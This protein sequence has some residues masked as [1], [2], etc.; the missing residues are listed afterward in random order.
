MQSVGYHDEHGRP[1]KKFVATYDEAVAFIDKN[2]VTVSRKRPEFVAS[3]RYQEGES[4]EVATDSV[5]VVWNVYKLTD[6]TRGAVGFYAMPNVFGASALVGPAASL[7]ELRRDVFSYVEKSVLG[8]GGGS[9]FGLGGEAAGST[10]MPS[11]VY[12]APHIRSSLHVRIGP[13]SSRRR[14]DALRPGHEGGGG[15]RGRGGP[16]TAPEQALKQASFRCCPNKRTS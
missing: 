15:V 14:A 13:R 6:A 9:S 12:E 4:P 11:G 3:D 7:V 10:A 5:G 2:A 16:R 1:L 8:G